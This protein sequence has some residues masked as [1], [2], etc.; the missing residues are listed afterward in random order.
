MNKDKRKQ[1]IQEYKDRM[2]EMGVISYC[3]I[4]TGDTFLGISSDIKADFNSTTNK[5]SSGY[6][7]N[8]ELLKLWNTYGEEGF[9]LTIP[10]R[11]KYED[12]KK[13]HKLALEELRDECL[14]Q[15]ALAKKIWK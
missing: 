10:K 9:E 8:R 11:L 3:C 15:N 14:A 2:P 4:A 12:P 7:P 13:D 6:H 5:L 1:L